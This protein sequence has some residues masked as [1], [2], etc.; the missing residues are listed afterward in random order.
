M[1]FIVDVGQN[2]VFA[3]VKKS[4]FQSKTDTSI[5]LVRY[6]TWPYHIRLK[7]REAEFEPKNYKVNIFVK[8]NEITIILS[9]LTYKT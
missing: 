4:M 3:C 9:Y 2:L 5:A 7:E 6:L 1:F 8:K